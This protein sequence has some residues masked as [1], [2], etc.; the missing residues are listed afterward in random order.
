[1]D[2]QLHVLCVAHLSMGLRYCSH[3]ERIKDNAEQVMCGDDGDCHYVYKL[4]QDKDSDPNSL[5]QE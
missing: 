4:D 1:M 2:R 3:G 5:W